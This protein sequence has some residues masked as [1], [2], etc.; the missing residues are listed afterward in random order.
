MSFDFA[1]L[2]GDIKVAHIGG[3]FVFGYAS[4][5]FVKQVSRTL[6][7]AVGGVFVLL[8]SL[9]YAGL[10]KIDYEKLE[11]KTEELLD[12]NKD[13]K[14]DAN[15]LKIILKRTQN[16]LS[17]GLPSGSGFAAGFAAGLKLH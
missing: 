17:Y 4:G 9:A 15:D 2:L 7:F 6:A 10:I 5:Y 3:G 12:V 8:Q 16:F 1:K 14:L 11:K 13:G